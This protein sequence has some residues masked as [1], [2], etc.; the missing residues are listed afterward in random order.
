M[1]QIIIL[2][3][4]ELNLLLFSANMPYK[5]VKKTENVGPEAEDLIN[6]LKAVKIENAKPFA[7]A[8]QYNVSKDTVYRLVAA[9][10]VSSSSEE[11]EFCLV[12]T[13]YFRE[14]LTLYN[15]IECNTCK[16]VFHLACVHLT[17]AYF[18]CKNCDSDL[19]VSEEEERE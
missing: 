16:R 15:S 13:Q 2:A 4:F 11:D 1:S 5:Y 9:L 14:P 8:K 18:T 3:Y 10:M 7:V 6:M 19:D 12:C 17:G